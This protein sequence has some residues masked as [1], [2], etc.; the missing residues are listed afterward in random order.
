MHEAINL[1]IH[2][3]LTYVGQGHSIIIT[4]LTLQLHFHD[5]Q[6]KAKKIK[7]PKVEVREPS[8]EEEVVVTIEKPPAAEPTYTT[9]KRARIFPMI[10]KKVRGLADR[11]GVI[12]LEGEE[13]QRGL[14]EE[15][16]DYL[17]LTLDQDEATESTVES[18]EES[19]SDYT[20]YSEEESEFSESET[21][22]E[23]SE[24]ETPSEEEES[25]TPE[26][27]ESEST[28][29]EGEKARKNIFFARRRPVVEEIKEIKGKKEEPPEEPEE[30][31]VGEEE[32]PAEEEESEPA[33][34]EEPPDLE[35][36]DVTEEGSMESASAEGGVES[37]EESEASESSSSSSESQS[38]GPWGFQVPE[39]GTSKNANQKKPPGANSEGYNTAL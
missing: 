18:E 36:Q 25:S 29:S 5:F 37:E 3:C 24:S 10:F 15:D 38:G 13:W 31:K 33:P 6:E 20:E 14:E 17:K 34:M 19:S 21:T 28:E 23:E 8:E 4:Q 11:R 32:H 7:K 1:Q 35:S 2:F 39:Y 12:D 16:K 9:W 27:E 22:E 26:S 30:L